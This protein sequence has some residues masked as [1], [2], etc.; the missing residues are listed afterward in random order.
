MEHFAII[1]LVLL[2]AAPL[3]GCDD[4]PPAQAAPSTTASATT[5]PSGASPPASTAPVLHGDAELE[6]ARVLL[7]PEKARIDGTTPPASWP[8][9]DA[10]RRLG[11]RTWVVDIDTSRLP[12]G[13]PEQLTV[14]VIGAGGHTRRPKR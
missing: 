13:Y 6:A 2:V 7:R 4:E 3:V 8:E 1:S 5:A 12:G 11:D 14:E 10:V 9:H